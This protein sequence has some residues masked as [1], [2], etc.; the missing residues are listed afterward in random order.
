MIF[1]TNHY[2]RARENSEVV[3]KF[4]Q[5]LYIYNSIYHISYY[6]IIIYH[7][8][9]YYII[10]YH[11]SYYYIIIYHISYHIPY[12]I[13]YTIYHTIIL[14]YTI[15]HTIYHISY[16]IP[17]IIP[18]TIYHTILLYLLLY[19]YIMMY[20][21]SIISQCITSHSRKM[22]MGWPHGTW[23][24][25]AANNVNSSTLKLPGTL[26]FYQIAI[27]DMAQSK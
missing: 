15:Y 23:D 18:Y 5:I 24:F 16:H 27:E 7:I 3:M 21:K 12:I 1:N 6:Y 22:A 2:S 4:T 20:N 19:I 14:L 17:Y 10:I 25:G 26:W 8:S 9:Y 11:I 13:P